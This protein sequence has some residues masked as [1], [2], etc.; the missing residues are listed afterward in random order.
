MKITTYLISLFFLLS[1]CSNNITLPNNYDIQLLPNK[2]SVTEIT[3]LTITYIIPQRVASSEGI[4]GL[5]FPN[6]HWGRDTKQE[7]IIVNFDNKML[8]VERRT[9]NGIAGSGRIY[10]IN[11]TKTNELNNRIIT[12]QPISMRTY[13]DGAILPFPLPEFNLESYLTSAVVKYN[14]ELNSEFPAESIRA[15]FDRILEKKS[16]SYYAL[17]LNNGSAFIRIKTDPYRNGSKILINSELFNMKHTNGVIDVSKNI[18]ELEN[19]IKSIVN[20]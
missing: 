14:F 1:A 18:L 11:I 15:N 10:N 12:L 4:I 19:Y 17:H 2:P 7:K 5:N 9:D 16:N 6:S 3:N 8:K 13:Q 20:S